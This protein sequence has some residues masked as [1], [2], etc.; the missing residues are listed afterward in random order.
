M[1]GEVKKAA[2]KLLSVVVSGLFFYHKSEGSIT[3]IYL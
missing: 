2:G 3:I 1:G